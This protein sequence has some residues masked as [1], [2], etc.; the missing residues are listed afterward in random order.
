MEALARLNPA[1][2]M[3]DSASAAREN[4]PSVATSWK[5]SMRRG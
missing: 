4:E 2:C 3:S 5:V 1:D